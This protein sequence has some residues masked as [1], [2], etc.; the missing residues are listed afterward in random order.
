MTAAIKDR[1]VVGRLDFAAKE[2]VLFPGK[3]DNLY[4]VVTGLVR[5]FTVDD[6]GSGVTLRYIKPGGYFGEEVLAERPR[7]YFAE[8]V[9]DTQLEVVAAVQLTTD[10]Q[11]ALSRQLAEALDRMGRSCTGWQANHCAPGGCRDLE[12]ATRAGSA[13]S[14]RYRHSR[15]ARDMATAVGSV[16]RRGRGGR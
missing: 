6:D 9:T 16:R 13:C 8:A 2:A 7:R 14:M 10:E 11:S 1:P 3:A 15:H 4:R 12:S 5:L